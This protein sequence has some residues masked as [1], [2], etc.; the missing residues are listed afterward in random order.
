MIDNDGG[1]VSPSITGISNAIIQEGG[2]L[3]FTVS[4]SEAVTE[5]TEIEISIINKA[6]DNNPFNTSSIPQP[7]EAASDSDY[8]TTTITVVFEVGQDT[9]MF[10]IVTLTDNED[11][12]IESIEVSTGNVVAGTIEN[13]TNAITGIGIITPA[14]IITGHVYLDYN[15]NNVQDDNETNL[16]GV[17]VRVEDV[18]GMIYTVFTDIN[19]DWEVSGIPFGPTK[20]SV[21]TSSLPGGL[22]QTENTTGRT[23]DIEGITS[24]TNVDEFTGRNNTF[25]SND[26][27][28]PRLVLFKSGE[29]VDTNNNGVADETDEVN[30]VYKIINQGGTEIRDIVLTDIRSGVNSVSFDNGV[31]QIESLAP[32]GGEATFRST[33]N[34]TANEII[35]LEI[36]SEASVSGNVVISGVATSIEDTHS[37]DLNDI[38]ELALNDILNDDTIVK[39]EENELQIFNAISPNG[40]DKNDFFTIKG[41]TNTAI[42][43]SNTVKIYNR[44]GVEV[45]SAD[46]YN[47]DDPNV[48]GEFNPSR[49]FYGESDGRATIAK[50]DKLP[51]G[52]YFY[53][54]QYTTNDGAEKCLSGYLYINR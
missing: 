35:V 5:R 25:T 51:V 33:Y 47:G 12:P 17:E 9:G 43:S 46:D 26:G 52:T 29:Y 39:I 53:V 42:T 14:G 3:E 31:F 34:P 36:V 6:V 4:L 24:I 10:S 28:A 2:D 19:G 30:Y 8:N 1:V 20:S 23:D 11:E 13:E 54:I 15:A 32:N 41:I 48:T 50:G 16:E 37:D 45:F 38:D 21:V 40:D 44:W 18:N 7:S 22:F 49:A 27:F